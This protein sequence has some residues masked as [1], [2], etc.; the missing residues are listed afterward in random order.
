MLL[1]VRL[2]PGAAG[3]ADAAGGAVTPGAGG[4]AAG[5]VTP[6]A[7]GAAGLPCDTAISNKRTRSASCSNTPILFTYLLVD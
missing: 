7:T 2:H 6:G 5:A 4:I 3:G 1:V